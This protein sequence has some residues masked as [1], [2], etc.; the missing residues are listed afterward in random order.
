MGACSYCHGPG[1]E[2]GR[3]PNLAVP[4]LMRA[5][6]D[7]ALYVIIR[8]GIEGTE[9]PGVWRM[10]DREVWQVVAYVRSLGRVPR[11]AVSGDAARGEQIYRTKGNCAQCHIMAGQGG[12]MG[13]D[14][15]EIGA[16]R[17]VEYLR[18]SL[19]EPGAAVPT[20]FLQVTVVTRDGRKITGIRLNES[21][22]SVQLRDLS[23]RFH[24]FLK[25]EVAEVRK[26][27]GQ[28]PMPS[29]KDILTPAEVEDLVA[30]MASLRGGL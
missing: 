4:R 16:R 14:L 22:F 29:Y 23:D 24:S 25:S 11:Q 13:P 27:K 9:M 6:N 19:L 2:G 30:Y 3:G 1:G 10:L 18:Q 20:D 28:S 21:T 15:T 7:Q 12:R 17:N 26:E 5:P 8:R